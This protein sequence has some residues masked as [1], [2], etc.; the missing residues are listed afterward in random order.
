MHNRAMALKFTTSYLA[1]SITLLR[2]YKELG[3]QA[4]A[5][6]SDEGLTVALDAVQFDRHHREAPDWQHA[7]ALDRFSYL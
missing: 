1:D 4:M 7:L 3:D 6:V 2:Y 5:Q